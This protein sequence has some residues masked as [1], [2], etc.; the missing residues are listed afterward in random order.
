M[1]PWPAL[2]LALVSG[3]EPPSPDADTA[4]I[5][6]DRDFAGYERWEVVTLDGGAEDAG[7]AA[8]QRRVFLNARPAADAGE[9]PVGTVLVKELPS[10][11]FAMVKR[12]AGYNAKGA[13]GWEWFELFRDTPTT[14]GIKWRGLGPP[15]GEDYSA[16][17]QSCNECHGA[18]VLNDSVLTPDFQLLTP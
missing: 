10:T 9:W 17:G 5:A 4:F 15:L 12:G 1:R 8:G 6:L 14:V 7:H 2:V 13:R 3:C 18:Q 16:T 11:T